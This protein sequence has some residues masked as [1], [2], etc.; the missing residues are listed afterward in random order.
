MKKLV[1]KEKIL[2]P[3]ENLKRMIDSLQVSQAAIYNALAFRS[4]SESA[5]KIRD[6]ALKK[7]G[8]KTVRIPVY[9][10]V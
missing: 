6:T 1:R 10:N 9:I 2:V 8:G 3:R 4:D 7:Y 5:A